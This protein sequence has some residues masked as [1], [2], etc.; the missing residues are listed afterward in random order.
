MTGTASINPKTGSRVIPIIIRP[1]AAA[2]RNEPSIN[3]DIF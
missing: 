1:E 2:S 3:L